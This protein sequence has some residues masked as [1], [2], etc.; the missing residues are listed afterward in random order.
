MYVLLFLLSL[1]GLIVGLVRPEKVLGNKLGSAQGAKKK[2]AIIYGLATLAFF[3][4]IGATAEPKT[5]KG[6]VVTTQPV[7]VVK[8]DEPKTKVTEVVDG[9]TIKVDTAGSKE[10]IRLIG[11][12]TPETKDPRKS[13]QC[14]GEEASKKLTE[15]LTGK[16]VRLERDDTQD[17]KDKYGR[18]L[19]YVYLTDDVLVNKEMI[20]QGY[21][22]EYTYEKPYKYQAD[23]KAAQKEAEGAQ[24][25]L[26]APGACVIEQS[27]TKQSTAPVEATTTKQDASTSTQTSTPAASTTTDEPASTTASSGVV[28]MSSTGICH[29]PGTTYYEK[30]TNFT[31]YGSVDE[32]IAAGGRLPKR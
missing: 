15:M 13:V 7:A 28:K 19:R 4:L 22:F 29:A 5:T 20:S 31:S 30:T 10:T 1:A 8:V 24:R 23:F 27:T 11:L 32:C 26:W 12:D 14:F 9:D 6:D 3:I 21:G 18:S 17:D 25:G 16:E 2:A